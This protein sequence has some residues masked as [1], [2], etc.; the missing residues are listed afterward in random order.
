MAQSIHPPGLHGAPVR[1]I[2]GAAKGFIKLL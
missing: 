2:L 1:L